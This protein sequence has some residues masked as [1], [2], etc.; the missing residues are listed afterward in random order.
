MNNRIDFDSCPI[1]G[2]DV[3]GDPS[4]RCN[5][6]MLMLIDEAIKASNGQL[7]LSFHLAEVMQ[8]CVRYYRFLQSMSQID[9]I[10]ECLTTASPHRI[11]HG[12][13]IHSNS[14]A[15]QLILKHQIPIGIDSLLVINSSFR[16]LL[17]IELSVSNNEDD[18][19][20]SSIILAQS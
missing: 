11:G 18:S 2:F 17:N 6:R 14:D 7:K 13:F 15:I 19:R 12:T 16:D 5:R 8:L 4:Y 3:S 10:Y 9:E 20:Q 1:V